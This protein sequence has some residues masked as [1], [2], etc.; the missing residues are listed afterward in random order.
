MQEHEAEGRKTLNFY[1]LYNVSPVLAAFPP[2]EPPL[3][4]EAFAGTSS[5]FFE[6]L[7]KF[8]SQAVKQLT[9]MP[10]EILSASFTD[11][12]KPLTPEQE[13]WQ[14]RLKDEFRLR[15]SDLSP[16]ILALVQRQ[17]TFARYDYWAKAAYLSVEEVLWL[18]VGLEPL[19]EFTQLLDWPS[20]KDGK[21]D[22]VVEHVKAQCE[23]LRRNFGSGRNLDPRA[24][25]TWAEAVGY[26][27]HPG[28]RRMV[29]GITA[30]QA[31]TSTGTSEPST[32]PEQQ[33]AKGMDAREKLSM[34]KLLTAIAI[35][36]YG[37]DPDAKRGP[38][39]KELEGIAA[40]LGLELTHDTIRSYLRL[41][42]GQL[43]KDW[44]LDD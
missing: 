44:K 8:R 25:Q 28:F 22:D 3:L 5:R 21:V 9:A 23:L 32:L 4:G 20:H 15:F 27:L 19:P 29:H 26:D 24:V 33:T 34:A 2:E 11:R 14:L 39:P 1:I 6:R 37:Y 42:A 17:R 43:P 38:I 16:W 30:R 12:G 35:D 36:A 7:G 41:G 31:Q 40:R 10:F 18:G 13:V